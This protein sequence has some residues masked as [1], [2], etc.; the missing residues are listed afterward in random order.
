M[1]F[2][3]SEWCLQGKDARQE[4]KAGTQIRLGSYESKAF[5]TKF[6][7]QTT[8]RSFV[9]KKI[10]LS[11]EKIALW[12]DDSIQTG[13]YLPANYMRSEFLSCSCNGMRNSDGL[14]RRGLAKRSGEVLRG[15]SEH[16][17]VL[18]QTGHIEKG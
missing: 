16:R 5:G 8:S 18:P 9:S 1:Q 14:I 15:R 10:L 4:S 2:Q 17:I 7:L 13:T 3:H 11:L 12:G 6:E